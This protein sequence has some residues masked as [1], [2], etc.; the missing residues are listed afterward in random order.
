MTVASCLV[1]PEGVVFGSDSTTSAGIDNGFHYLNH[2]QKIL[3]L[4]ENA[5]LGL[6]TW[7]LTTLG[8]T[9]FR[10]LAARLSDDFRDSPPPSVREATRRWAEIVWHEYNLQFEDELKRIRVLEVKP[11]RTEEEDGELKNGLADLF[12][13]FCI[14][15]Y[16][17]PDRKPEAYSLELRPVLR[18]PP[19]PVAVES[20]G[21]WGQPDLFLRLYDGYDL[22]ARQA[23]LE[24]PFWT[25]TR[26]ELD[27]LL[28]SRSLYSPQINIRDAVDFVHFSVYATI[29]A[30]KFSPFGQVCGGP[31]ELAVITTDRSFRWVRHKSWDSA[32]G[33]SLS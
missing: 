7:G 10:T 20:H 22:H 25:G 26:D 30:L 29:K 5:T 9:S 6:M 15:G 19:I 23:I 33:D 21:F 27:N 4:G 14:G 18:S 32:I 1:V 11:D 24:S 28:T 2:S 13:G 3:E 12:V 16:C 31:I 8:G 17:L